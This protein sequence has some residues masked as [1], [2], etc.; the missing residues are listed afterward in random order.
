ML[1]SLEQLSRQRVVTA[2]QARTARALLRYTNVTRNTCTKATDT[3]PVI[4]ARLMCRNLS[5][6]SI[7]C[8][9]LLGQKDT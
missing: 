5:N 3:G 8:F 9:S 1:H 6:G 2:Q 7:A 4:L